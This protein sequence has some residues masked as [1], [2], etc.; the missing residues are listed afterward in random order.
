VLRLTSTGV[1]FGAF[2][3][4]AAV[5]AAVLLAP[6]GHPSPWRGPGDDVATVDVLLTD[7]EPLRD[8]P[9]PAPTVTP[10][11]G[12]ATLWPAHTHPYPVPADHD[13][14]PHD[15]N[16]QHHV[17]PA[18]PD[19]PAAAAPTETAS[20]DT[21]HFTIAIGTGASDAHGPVSSSGVAPS[22]EDRAA[23]MSEQEVDGPARLARSVVPPYPASARAEGVEGDVRLEL[24]VGPSGAVESARVVRGVG[25]GLDEAALLAVREF[26]F[27]PAT[28]AGSTVRVRMGWSMAFRLQ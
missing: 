14:T 1:T 4:S 25:H 26:R 19:V 17:A 24:V 28:K 6:M 13:W 5:H 18:T 3:F 8:S 11:A 16:L 10:P 21:P 27:A 20:D 15:P 7:P 23:P 2:G 9:E 12:R 22:H